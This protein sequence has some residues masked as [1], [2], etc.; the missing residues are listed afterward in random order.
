MTHS[1]KLAVILCSMMV[2]AGCEQDPPRIAPVATEP[3]IVT[4]KLGL[5]ADKAAKALDVISGIEQRRNPDIKTM[6]DLT[7]V[8]P[9]LAQPVTLRW[10]GPA[11]KVVKALGERA[12]LRYRTR[13]DAPAAPIIVNIDAY[14]QPIIQILRDIGLQAGR[15]ADVTVDGRNGA[16]ELHYAPADATAASAPMLEGSFGGS[17]GRAAGRNSIHANEIK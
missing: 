4:V 11:D 12:G 2:L 5:A 13:G 1:F 17:L 7:D 6:D 15:R 9:N 16:V 14:Q 10:S 3:D 8:P